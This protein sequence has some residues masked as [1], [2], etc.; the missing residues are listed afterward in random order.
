M[1][2]WR[3][4]LT[5]A[6]APSLPARGRSDERPAGLAFRPAIVAPADELLWRVVLHAT[7]GNE[8]RSKGALG[9]VAQDVEVAH[10]IIG[11]VRS[12]GHHDRYC[13]AVEDVHPTAYRVPEPVGTRVLDQPDARVGGRACPD[14]VRGAVGAA[15]VDQIG[16]ASC[17]ERV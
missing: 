11:A 15:V 7:A 12:V 6:E 17:R 13:V 16:R 4:R 5:I 1:F 8:P 2:G 10:E 14:L 3:T 9:A